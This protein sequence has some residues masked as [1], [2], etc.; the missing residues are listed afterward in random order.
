MRWAFESESPHMD[1]FGFAVDFAL[2]GVCV[3]GILGGR[4]ARSYGPIGS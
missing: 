3:A 1:R 2:C 4:N